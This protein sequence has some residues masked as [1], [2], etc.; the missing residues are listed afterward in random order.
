MSRVKNTAGWG[1]VTHI[2]DISTWEAEAG[3]WISEFQA[4]PGYMVK[5]S[6]IFLRRSLTM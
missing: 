5:Q 4:N 1:M 2:C 6:F 3:K